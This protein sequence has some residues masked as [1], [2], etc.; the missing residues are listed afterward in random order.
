[1]SPFLIIKARNVNQKGGMRDSGASC[2]PLDDRSRK[3]PAVDILRLGYYEMNVSLIFERTP[4]KQNMPPEYEIVITAILAIV[5]GAALSW[6]LLRRRIPAA[7]ER[8]RSELMPELA[9]AKEWLRDR[10]VTLTATHE[11]LSEMEQRCAELEGERNQLDKQRAVAEQK[12]ENIPLLQAELDVQRCKSEELQEELKG[13]S[14]ALA[15]ETEKAA[16]VQDMSAMLKEK[17]QDMDELRRKLTDQKATIAELNTRMEEE[18]SQSEEKLA[19][20]ND[21]RA[22]LTNHFRM[23]AQDIFEEKGKKFTEQNQSGLDALL[24]PFRN[25]LTDFKKRVDD[26]YV[27]EAK[28]RASLR[29]ELAN[30]RLLNMKINQEAM[31]LTRALKGDRKAQGNWGELVLERVLE[32]SGLRKGIEYET[33][34]GF[35]DRDNKLLKPDVI[36]HLPEGKDVVVDSKVSLN[37]YE[38]YSSVEDEGE[39]AE[40]LV[41][42]IQAVRNHIEGLGGKDYSGLKGLRSLDFVLMF[43]PIE[44]AFMAAFQNDENLFSVAFAH[45]IVVVTP[46]TLLATLRTIENIWRYERQNQNA[47][48]IAERAGAVYDKLRGFVEDME[49]LGKQLSTA[50][51][52]YYDAMGKL[53]TGQGNLIS[54]ASRFVEL[55][56]KVKKALPKSVTEIAETGKAPEMS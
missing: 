2:L 11:R 20:L 39:Q 34:G 55:G 53:T 5:F 14:A 56:I 43:M 27:S 1:M 46:T 3:I 9:A 45:K 7:V 41:A 40:A 38:R 52:T 24:T 17:E 12:T 47:Q 30:L 51:S 29:Q 37:D 42:H 50:R 28:D 44:A 15:R 19:L 18:R 8:G 22:E 10:E 21:A 32:Q 35:R 25:Q 23:L 48:A 33:Q 16:R 6:I 4:R 26:V 54:Q 36:I 49:R 13:M 31:N